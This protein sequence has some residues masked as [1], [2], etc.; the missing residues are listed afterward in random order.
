[1]CCAL[2]DG[3]QCFIKGIGYDFNKEK[4]IENK[5]VARYDDRENKK[6]WK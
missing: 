3:V 6:V 1:M 5:I 2:D 4:G